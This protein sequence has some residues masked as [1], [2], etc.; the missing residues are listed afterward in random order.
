MKTR[1][2]YLPSFCVVAMSHYILPGTLERTNILEKVSRFL[3]SERA[4]KHFQAAAPWVF[5]SCQVGGLCT[6]LASL[7]CWQDERARGSGKY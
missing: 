1:N 2:K 4:D 5:I 3:P 7:V 6:Q